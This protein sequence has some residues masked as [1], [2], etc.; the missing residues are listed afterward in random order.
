M[1]LGKSYKIQLSGTYSHDANCT[2]SFYPRIG[3]VTISSITINNT[4]TFSNTPFYIDYTF[5]CLAVGS[6]GQIHGSGFLMSGSTYN[7]IMSTSSHISTV[8]TTINNNIGF[9]TTK[10]AG[11]TLSF[12]VIHSTIERLA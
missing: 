4:S 1:K 12:T 8:N 7:L 10:D 9:V 11:P 2:F 3:S 5:K 6:N